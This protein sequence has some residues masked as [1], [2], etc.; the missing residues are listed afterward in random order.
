MCVNMC[1]YTRHAKRR[2]YMTP[3]FY[4][5]KTYARTHDTSKYQN[6][7]APFFVH[8]EY[9]MRMYPNIYQQLIPFHDVIRYL[10]CPRWRGTPLSPEYALLSIPGQ[11]RQGTAAALKSTQ[12]VCV[13]LRV[14][15][16][17]NRRS[18]CAQCYHTHLKNK[19]EVQAHDA[20]NP[21]PGTDNDHC[22]DVFF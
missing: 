17:R 15:V 3:L 18:C 4:V 10:K 9:V 2:K 7:D 11:Q 13:C 16:T 14:C 12:N 19:F 1:E 6:N 21:R 22:L 20:E 5:C 8:F